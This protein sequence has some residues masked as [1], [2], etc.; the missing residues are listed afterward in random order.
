MATS[1]VQA[2]NDFLSNTVNLR[3]D[4]TRTARSSRDWLVSQL[5]TFPDK[6]DKFPRIYSEKTIFFGSFS[7]NTKK[8]PLDDI[9][10]MFCLHG[11]GSTYNEGFTQVTIDVADGANKLQALCHDNTSTLNS[12]KV[13]N[14]FVSALKTV[15]KYKNADAKINQEAAVLVL[16]SYDWNFDIVPCFFTSPDANGNTYYL[17]PDGNGNWKKTNPVL[18]RERTQRINQAHD[19]NVLN[20]IRVMKYWN[21][22]PTMPS[23]SSYLLETMILNYYE[24]TINKASEYVDVNIP[25]L[26]E[27][28]W[29]HVSDDIQDPKGIQGNINYLTAEERRKISARAW[30]DKGKALEA[31]KYDSDTNDSS[32][33]RMWAEVFGGEFPKYG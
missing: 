30:E 26:L 32:S 10:I 24:S 11:E 4:E 15:E 18:D 33:I 6:V 20:I 16:S 28:I 12:I 1:V 25:N 21:K 13:V 22:R 2:F 27:Y 14:K 29:L 9:D 8:R 7:R 19:G 3:T 17:I 23:M 5:N 31:R